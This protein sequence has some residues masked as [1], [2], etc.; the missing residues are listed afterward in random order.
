[1]GGH[2]YVIP[3]ELASHLVP[4]PERVPAESV[5][6]PLWRRLLGGSPT[7]PDLP[8]LTEMPNGDR[9]FDVPPGGLTRTLVHDLT[10]WLHAR[11]PKPS[12]GSAVVLQY[13][14]DITP[15]IY[16]RGLQRRGEEKPGF[17]VQVSFS[18]CAGEAETS[19]R[20]ASHWTELWYAS[21]RNRI[22]S[23]HLVPFGFTPAHDDPSAA[24]GLMFLPAGDLGYLEYTPSDQRA[25]DEPAFAL[26][27]SL[28][29]A[30]EADPVLDRLDETFER[31]MSP[32]R[33]R[34]QICEPDFGDAPAGP[35]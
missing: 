26:D 6:V 33:C 3:G 32:P 24:E 8:R 2:A 11:M 13:L 34:C 5:P 16:V 23:A 29:Q 31:F 9:H 21:E 28:T 12:T 30:H 17:Y 1:M 35:A 19:A 10:T 14:T 7:A 4:G 25:P 20:A 27:H 15:T 22:A 18:G